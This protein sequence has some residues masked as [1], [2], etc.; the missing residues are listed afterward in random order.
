[1]LLICFADALDIASCA[2]H[3]GQFSASAQLDDAMEL[4]LHIT[5]KAQTAANV[6]QIHPVAPDCLAKKDLCLVS[7]THRLGSFFTELLSTNQL[8]ELVDLSLQL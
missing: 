4:I 1:M 7:L 5:S 3:F 8:L 2:S 6:S